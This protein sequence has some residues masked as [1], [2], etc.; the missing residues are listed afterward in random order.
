MQNLRQLGVSLFFATI[1]LALVFGGLLTALAEDAINKP[2]PTVTETRIP[3]HEVGTSSTS[4]PGVLPSITPSLSPTST[5]T[6]PPPTSCPPP[7]GWVAYIIQIGDNLENLS[8]R[9][10]ITSSTLKNANCLIADSLIPNT[11]LYVPPTETATFIPCGPPAGWV[12]YIVEAGDNL[13]RTGL[14]Y[15]VS[16]AELQLANCMGGGTQI[17][18]GQ[19][20]Y[21]PNVA[22]S[23]PL[24][25]TTPSSTMTPSA[26]AT[27]S[28]PIA[29]FTAI[30][31]ATAET[32][33]ETP[34]PTSSL[35][36]TP[37]PTETE[38]PPSST[39]TP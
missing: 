20:L 35:T 10:G 34:L 16:T 23:T 15:R 27:L 6:L 21:V 38:I 3:T 24:F 30:E 8:A 25:T 4:T 12:F 14:K 2:P 22:T 5:A 29:T 33:T 1:S 32:P 17:K 36:L 26:S 7:S 37:P 9:H 11:R 18:V 19:K 31:T 28:T 13:F 39:Y